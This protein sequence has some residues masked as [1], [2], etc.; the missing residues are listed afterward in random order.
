MDK[1]TK[2]RYEKKIAELQ[3]E[4]ADSETKRYEYKTL[5]VEIFNTITEMV[6]SGKQVN[7]GW[8]LNRFKRLFL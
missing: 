6:Q 7:Q 2:Y 1:Q 5:S 4:L 8:L 3:K